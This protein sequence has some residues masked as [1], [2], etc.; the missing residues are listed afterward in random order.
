MIDRL[1]FGK[2]KM[3]V[4]VCQL[5]NDS[6]AFARDWERLVAHVKTERSELVLLPEMPF[7]PWFALSPRYDP[8]IW[9][10]AVKTHQEATPLLEKLS[11][12]LVC[13]SLPF[14]NKGKRHNQAFIWDSTSGFRYAHMISSPRAMEG[15]RKVRPIL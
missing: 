12:S 2:N 3:K 9:E 4:T 6:I 13:G 5:S 7:S 14:N 10:S 15:A 11:P 1:I 8:K